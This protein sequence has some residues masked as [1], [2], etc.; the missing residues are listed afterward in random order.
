LVVVSH[1]F[2]CLWA[3][4]AFVEA[5]RFTEEA[6]ESTPNWIWNWYDSNNI[7]GGLNPIGWFQ[8]TDR[9][10]LSLF[11]AV[12]TI[13]SIGYGN[14]VPVTST[15]WFVACI[16]MLLSGI[17]WAYI[18]GGLVGVTAAMNARSEIYRE[19]MDQANAMIKE[20]GAG[21]VLKGSDPDVRAVE[22]LRDLEHRIK[23]YIYNQYA[24]SNHNA[25][26]SDLSQTFPV[27]E[28][29]SPDL[30][31]L[32][33][34]MV[35]KDDLETVP[36]L[37]SR[38]LS[39]EARSE[40]AMECVFLEF[41]AGEVVDIEKGV[42]DLGRGIF[43]FRKGLGLLRNHFSLPGMPCGDRK[44][45]VEDGH[46]AVKSNL[47]FLSFAKVVFIP[48]KAVLAA[49]VKNPTA[50][51]ECARWIYFMTTLHSTSFMEE[52]SLETVE[53]EDSA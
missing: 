22:D 38:F 43:V 3:L 29:L 12:Q 8:D 42:G 4:V 15:E 51:K 25:C 30:Q 40:V 46:P 48:R 9:Y 39:I 47:F 34:L 53:E 11:W 6:L 1:W 13:T 17:M 41:A 26:I 18:I 20:F 35:F 37:S 44:V 24:M 16:L 33:A 19:R 2:A 10:I 45:L 52:K 23:N 49:F 32:S 36:Y 28:T 7:Q 5:G 21:E 31:R 50:W 14:I 27:L